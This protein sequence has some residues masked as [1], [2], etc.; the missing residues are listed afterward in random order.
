[1][2]PIGFVLGLA[3]WFLFSLLS[4]RHGDDSVA[5]AALCAAALAAVMAWTSRGRGG[6]KFLDVAGVVTFGAIAV[7]GFIGGDSLG[8][9]LTNFARGGSTLL[10]AVLMLISAAT[11]PFTEQYAK[12]SVPEERWSSPL[13][14]A[15]NRKVS[16]VWGLAVLFMG[17]G[18]VVAGLVEPASAPSDGSR[19]VDLLLNWMVPIALLVLAGKYTKHAV[20]A[21]RQERDRQ[22]GEVRSPGN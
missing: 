19:P 12:D 9:W 3:P 22:P 16:A 20:G 5:I 14:R 11:V 15:T 7:A 13:F 6:I 10:L 21:A 8:E 1:M 18:H 17:V 2:N 4:H